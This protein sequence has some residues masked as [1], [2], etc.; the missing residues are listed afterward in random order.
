MKID[1]GNGIAFTYTA[2]VL[3]IAFMVYS[4]FGEKYDLVTSDYYEQEIKY[5]D[6]INS[7]TRTALL[8][9]QLEVAIDGKELVL[10]FPQKNKTVSGNLQCFRPS[11]KDKDFSLDFEDIKARLALPLKKFSKGKYLLKLS[12]TAKEDNGKESKEYYVE[13]SIFIP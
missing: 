1:W 3:F 6:K 5:Q 8:S 12:W 11:D 2:F 9:N 10:N 4:A 7:K 13:Q